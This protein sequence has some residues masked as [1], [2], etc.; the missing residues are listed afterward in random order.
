MRIYSCV[1]FLLGKE[2]DP[3]KDR[4]IRYTSLLSYH[5]WEDPFSCDLSFLYG[6]QELLHRL[7]EVFS[8]DLIKM[9]EQYILLYEGMTNFQ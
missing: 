2:E 3:R 5:V 8:R 9:V 1:I 7:V 4:L 6:T